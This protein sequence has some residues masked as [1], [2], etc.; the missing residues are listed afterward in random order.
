W[1]GSDAVIYIFDEPTKGVDV[2]AKRDIFRI[3]GD[4][5]SQ[6]KAIL[7]F[8]SELGEAIGIA[9]RVIVMCDGQ[10][11]KEFGRNEVTQEQLLFY[12]SAGREE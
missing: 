7:Y 3:I 10:F 9:D 12:A 4:L 11:V 5:A 8:T 6:Q 1:V 2:G